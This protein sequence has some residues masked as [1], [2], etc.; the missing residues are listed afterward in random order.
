MSGNSLWKSL[1]R[2]VEIQ[3][4]NKTQ[5][6]TLHNPRSYCF[7]GFSSMPPSPRIPPG[8][9]DSCQF[10]NSVMHFRGCV[11]VLVYEA[12]TF[13][14]A[15]LFSNPFDYNIFYVELAM[16]ISLHKAHRGNLEDIYNRMYSGIP[17]S[18]DKGTMLH[19]VKLGVCQEP[20]MVST[21]HVKVTATMS[22]AAKSIIRVIVE[23]QDGPT[24]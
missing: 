10:T 4:D 23:N 14:L 15:I 17:A 3:I 13:T 2:S 12:D 16:E 20:V 21:G 22:N 7:S 6:V 8:I 19:R 9:T 24:T 5:D 1:E 18:T 11:G